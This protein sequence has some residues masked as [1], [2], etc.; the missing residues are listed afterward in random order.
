MITNF[1][2]LKEI[3]EKAVTEHSPEEWDNYV[4][5]ACGSDAGL[6][7]SVKQLLHAHLQTGGPLDQH[8]ASVDVAA[9][10][11]PIA[12]RPG[13]LIGPYKLLEQIVEGGMGVVFM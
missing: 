6:Y 7:H 13:S 1:E 11:G 2:I 3:F 8:A 5:A 4:T 12:E 10:L 9:I